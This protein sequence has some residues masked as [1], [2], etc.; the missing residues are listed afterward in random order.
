MIY[1]WE[2]RESKEPLWVV[3]GMCAPC[4]VVDTRREKDGLVKLPSGNVIDSH[5]SSLYLDSARNHRVQS[6]LYGGPKRWRYSFEFKKALI[7]VREL[8]PPF[9]ESIQFR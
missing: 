1:R 2:T 8:A 4:D 5:P 7:I 9:K 6:G 3:N